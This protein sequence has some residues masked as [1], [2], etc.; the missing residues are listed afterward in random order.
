MVRAGELK[1]HITFQKV[2]RTSDGSGGFTD[3]WQDVLSTFAKVEEIRSNPYL[4]ASQEDI[5]T[6]LKVTIRYRPDVFL[7]NGNRAI[8]RGFTFIVN[9]IKVDPFRTSIE[10]FVHSEIET[11][12]RGI[13]ST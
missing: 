8:W 7:E 1:D 4:V 9:N 12:N 3:T 11:S 5:N 6:Y 2:V 10:I 13:P